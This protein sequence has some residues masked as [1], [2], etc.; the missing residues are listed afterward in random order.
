MLKATWSGN[1]G[2]MGMFNIPV[3]LF[4]AIEKKDNFKRICGC[5]GH[6]GNAYKCNQCGKELDFGAWQ[7]GYDLGGD[8]IVILDKEKIEAL[9]PVG[10]SDMQVLG[11][12][13]ELDPL[14][15][16]G[17]HYFIGVAEKKSKAKKTIEV[18]VSNVKKIYAVFRD[19][20]RDNGLIAIGKYTD[21]GNEHYVCIRSYKDGLLLSKLYYSDY[22]RSESEIFA[23]YLDIRSTA[24]HL[25]LMKRI[26]E[27]MNTNISIDELRDEYTQRVRGLVDTA[28]ASREGFGDTAIL[29]QQEVEKREDVRVE[30][31][32]SFTAMLRKFAKAN[33]PEEAEAEGK[34]VQLGVAIQK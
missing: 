11:F 28:M 17:S 24:E 21:R 1:L 32:D 34:V 2:I 25:E 5:G 12:V 14:A 9:K 27:Q 31:E 33:E 29:L 3:K 22:R 10:S 26:M 6:V 30:V 4:T 19:T 23:D 16:T 15:I 7:T 8:D 13:Q 18:E 20:L